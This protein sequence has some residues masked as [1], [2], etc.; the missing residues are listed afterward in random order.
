VNLLE[1]IPFLKTADAEAEVVLG[2]ED[3]KAER[4]AFHRNKVRNGPTKFSTQTTGQFRRE[5]LR[6][7]AR[8]TKNARRK[9]IRDHF[10]ALRE[11]AVLR[12]HLQAAGI[13]QYRTDYQPAGGDV[14]NAIT[15]IIGHFADD[16]LA[17]ERGRVEITEPVV[18][19][20]LQ[21]ALNRYQ[22]LT[23]RPQTPL[24]PAYVLPVAVAA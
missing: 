2:E 23:G 3:A 10:A 16:K 17:D 14:V 7:L 15:W 9:Q 20:S 12:G 21:A 8:K 6:G 24:S 11:I 5:Q 13:I 1:K 4:I 22:H 19:A 18:R